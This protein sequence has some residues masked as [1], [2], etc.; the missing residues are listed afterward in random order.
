M[1]KLGTPVSIGIT[2]I[3]YIVEIEETSKNVCDMYILRIKTY[4]KIKDL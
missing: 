3:D 1:E 2:A 4:C